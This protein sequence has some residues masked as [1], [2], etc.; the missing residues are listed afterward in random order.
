M[1]I[2]IPLARFAH[3]QNKISVL[4]VIRDICQFPRRAYAPSGSKVCSVGRKGLEE[5]AAGAGAADGNF[6]RLV[7]IPIQ[8]DKNL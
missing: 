3:T 1:R 8:L 5:G 4:D 2:K 6:E 7:G